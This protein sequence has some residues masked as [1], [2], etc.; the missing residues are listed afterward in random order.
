MLSYLSPDLEQWLKFPKIDGITQI[1]FF[2]LIVIGLAAV[3]CGILEINLVE[4]VMHSSNSSSLITMMII[5]II[6]FGIVGNAV[7]Q[8]LNVNFREPIQALNATIQTAI[9][10]DGK[11][12]PKEIAR[13]RHLSA[14]NHLGIDFNQ[15]RHLTLITYDPGL[16][17]MEILVNLKDIWLKCTTIYN[18]TANCVI[19]SE[20]SNERN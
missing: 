12:V 11:I 4:Q 5:G 18:Q 3:I 13:A 6:V 1:M 9:D 14:I 19:I 2:S 7:D 17:Y 15:P 20:I 8:L 10:Y 16:G